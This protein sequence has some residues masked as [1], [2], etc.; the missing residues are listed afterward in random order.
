MSAK[1]KKEIK[2]SVTCFGAGKE[3]GRSSILVEIADKQILLDCGVNIAATDEK[4]K[5]PILKADDIKG[6]DLVLISHIH[7]DH[8]AAVPWLTEKMGCKAPVYMTKASK[9]MMPIMLDDFIK[10][11][12]NPPYTHDDLDKCIKSVK[13]VDFYSRFEAAPDIWVQGFPAGHILGATA[14]YVQV[15]GLSFVY[16]G[17]FS[18]ISDHHLSGHAIPRLFPDVLITESTY[19][20]KTR[21]T[22]AKRE[23]SFVQLVHATV[24]EG[25]KVLI[26]VFAVGRLQ[27]ICLMLEDYW[28]RMGYEDPIYY[29]TNLGEKAMEVYKRCA[30][31]MN[32]TVQTN[33]FD[34]N[35][36]AFK[37]KYSRYYNRKDGFTSPGGFVMLATSG[38]L[39]P[40]TPSYN[41]F[42][43]EKW[44]DDPKNLI[45][46]P[47]FCGP[48]TLGRAVLTRDPV[49][50]RVKYSCKKL[51]IDLDIQIRCKV[52][53]VSFSAH[54][55]QFE[56]LSMCYRVEPGLVL[57][58]HGDGDSVDELAKQIRSTCLFKAI[59][60]KNGQKV[61][62]EVR[63]P[64]CISIERE[65]VKYMFGQP[66]KCEGIILND[67]K[68]YK[69]ISIP[70]YEKKYGIKV[71]RIKLKRRVK[72]KPI[73]TEKELSRDEIIALRRE[74]VI[75]VLN[76]MKILITCVE[77]QTV[78]IGDTKIG[79][80]EDMILFTYYPIDKTTINRICVYF[81]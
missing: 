30:T 34:N 59:A 32:P 74:N 41:F 56:I 3:V 29:S 57:T 72:L 58:V 12:E 7:T 49:T 38:M 43:D 71:N 8:L 18:A 11:T 24:A 6:V 47:G 31:W 79:I 40:K 54:A 21:D 53:T 64:R 76:K 25:G 62:S 28:S 9:M 27:E 1:K 13:T 36:T 77:E 39:N 80:E 22:I 35:S 61:D 73:V 70:H 63:N 65:C 66:S 78:T 48:N 20:N 16:T 17:D 69:M 2:C 52:E 5:L 19:G 51:N 33:L 42:I 50:N 14:F 23:R 44:Y 10:V 4:N 45:I 60:P 75:N 46:F 67:E 81:I 37:F 15:K 55:D 68:G 26:P